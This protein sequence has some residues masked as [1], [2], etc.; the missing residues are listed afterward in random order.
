MCKL[1]RSAKYRCD[2]HKENNSSLFKIPQLWAC[3]VKHEE[4]GKQKEVLRTCTKHVPP[5]SLIPDPHKE[6]NLCAAVTHSAH[7]LL[8]VHA[9]TII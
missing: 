1:F 7:R 4:V 8:H 3:T 5:S 6:M 9:G 2:N